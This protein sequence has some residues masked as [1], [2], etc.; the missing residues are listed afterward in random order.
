[1]DTRNY[2]VVK[3]VQS[4][5]DFSR[6]KLEELIW[7]A[8]S[9]YPPFQFVKDRNEAIRMYDLTIAEGHEYTPFREQSLW[10]ADLEALKASLRSLV[11]DSTPGNLQSLPKLV[12]LTNCSISISFLCK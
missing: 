9:K 3:A 7:E 6:E 10:S 4:A 11:P 1:V 5:F 8:H 2:V 12:Y